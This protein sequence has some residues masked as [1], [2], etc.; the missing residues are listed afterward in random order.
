MEILDNLGYAPYV[1]VAGVAAISLLAL[2]LFLIFWRRA[3]RKKRESEDLNRSIVEQVADGILLFDA[4]TKIILEANAA[5]RRALD[6][7]AQELKGREIYD[8]IAHER[9]SVDENVALTLRGNSSE[10]GTSI[11]E[12]KYRRKDGTLVDFEVSAGVVSH[13]GRKAICAVVRD[14]TGR[15]EAEER[16]REAEERYRGLVEQIPAIV[17]IEDVE[18]RATVYDSPQIERILG[19][20]RDTC[21]NDPGY[22]ESIIHPEDR[23]R[24]AVAEKE[25][26][27]SGS[28]E[29]EYRVHAKSGEVVWLRDEARIVHDEEG[30]PR[31]WQGAIFN[32]AEQKRTENALRESEERY[33][34]LVQL[35]PNIIA[36]QSGGNFVYMNAAGMALLGAS[37]AEE[38]IGK[39]VIDFVRDDYKKAVRQRIR[40][41]GRGESVE[42]MEQ[43]WV[44]LGGEEIE[45][46]AA[47]VPISY[48]GEPAAQ[49]VV[50]DITGRKRAEREMNRQKAELSRS[51]A[52]LEQFAYLIAHDLRAPLRSLD[53]FSRILLEDYS[54]ELDDEGRDYLERIRSSSEKMSAMIDELL[55]LSRLM[56]AEMQREEVDLSE[57]S[58]SVA[59]ELRAGDPD[60]RVEVIVAGGLK[61]EGDKRLLRIALANLMENAWKFTARSPRAR[62][63]F[64]MIEQGGQP[65]YFVRDNGT[66]FDMAHAGKLF[67]PF[68][69]LHSDEDF[70]GAGI[71]L[72]AV[73]RIIDRHGGRVWAEGEVGKGATFYFSLS[74]SQPV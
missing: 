58:R 67:G 69:R 34:S 55:N 43:K 52:E 71:G 56:R 57:I 44:G 25:S 37:E 65:V 54:N 2:L 27:E 53:G 11:G 47:A 31:F 30:K 61:A 22:W 46:E 5:L 36:V 40:K 28:F 24:V 14:V 32:I 35:S 45:V 49:I 20:P 48:R 18:T 42:A 6:Y 66:G 12:R 3:A 41:L 74:A 13:G 26:I 64:G 50:R 33:R 72:A 59:R 10:N 21:E 60:R 29:L 70:E 8:L 16:L 73:S 63:V 39:P 38:I 9:E 19:Y 17:Y 23:E 1:P 51:N 15:K 68:Q 62:I 4:E 7:D